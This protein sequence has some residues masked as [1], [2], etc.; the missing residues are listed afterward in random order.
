MSARRIAVA[1]VVVGCASLALAARPA[2]AADDGPAIWEFSTPSST[3]RLL[4][5][6]HVLR[7]SDYPL[8]APVDLAVGQAQCLVFE[9]DLDDLDPIQSQSLVLALGQNEDGKSLRDIMGAPDYR[10]AAE[11][12]MELGIDLDLFS[13][14]E[15]WLAALTIMNTQFLKL[16]FL[17]QLG[18]DQQLAA[19]AAASGK[20][21]V[22]L[23]SLEFQLGLF[24]G[25]TDRMQSELLL[26]TLEEAAQLEQQMDDLVGAWRQG[27]DRALAAELG[28]SFANYP[29]LYRRL[30]TDRN[31]A[32]ID[33]I[34][35]LAA[36]DRDCLV[37]V[38]ALHL[39]G[40]DSVIDLL[41]RR[42]VDVRRW[43][44]GS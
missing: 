2:L 19:R 25:L 30:V 43:P 6:V 29:D 16:G 44:E 28:R 38:G 27:R 39:V 35:E 3:L 24:A 15:P 37:V 36:G 23:E 21:V 26:Q 4:G 34:L 17:P 40:P 5:S 7:E 41:R 31:A 8:P 1:I 12:S 11:R 22:G 9:L 20:E 32:W 42:G 18:L 33:R 14:V 10:R 13:G